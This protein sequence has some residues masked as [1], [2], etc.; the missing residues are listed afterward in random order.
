MTPDDLEEIEERKAAWFESR[1]IPDPAKSPPYATRAMIRDADCGF[2]VE[3]NR[4]RLAIHGEWRLLRMP[5][6]LERWAKEKIP[7]PTPELDP[8]VSDQEQ[9]QDTTPDVE[10]TADD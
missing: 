5:H 10:V 9:G 2:Q 4:W 6:A 8:E 1:E 7:V 3:G